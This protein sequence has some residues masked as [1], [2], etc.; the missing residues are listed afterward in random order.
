VRAILIFAAWCLVLGGRALP[1]E[2]LAHDPH[3]AQISPV[4]AAAPLAG[5][6]AGGDLSDARV[7]VAT[8]PSPLA[9]PTPPQLALP[10]LFS[11]SIANRD[12]ASPRLRARGPPIA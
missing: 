4:G 7:L 9:L 5:R 8:L 12:A 2:R 6:R 3:A 11:T 10:A 1:S